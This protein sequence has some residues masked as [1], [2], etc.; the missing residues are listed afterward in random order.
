MGEGEGPRCLFFGQERS[1][2]KALGF[3]FFAKMRR[4]ARRKEGKLKS[5][6]DGQKTS[7]IIE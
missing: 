6:E 3:G 1:E 5:S 7:S 2:E 4:K